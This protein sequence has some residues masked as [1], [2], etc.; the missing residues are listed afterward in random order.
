VF[1]PVMTY[2]G[3]AFLL[4]YGANA[5]RRALHPSALGSGAEPSTTLMATLGSCAAFTLLNPHVYLDMVVLIG[6]I[7]NARPASEQWPFATGASLASL[8]WFFALGYGARALG[9]W[10]GQP[11]VWRVIDFCIAGVMLL[12]ALKLLAG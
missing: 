3:V 10:L 11:K 5:L 2:G 8:A 6:S 7:A 12:L 1:V 4:W 9:P